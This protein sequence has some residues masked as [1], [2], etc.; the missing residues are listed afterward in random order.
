[1]ATIPSQ[2]SIADS[3][4][5]K[6]LMQQLEHDSHDLQRALEKFTNERT[7]VLQ[8]QKQAIANYE[9]EIAEIEAY[10][11]RKQNPLAE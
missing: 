11:S 2:E 6:R 8:N 10:Y 9:A 1:M 7:Q 3:L 4:A 5:A